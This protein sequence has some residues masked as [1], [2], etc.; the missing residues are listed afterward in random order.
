[1]TATVTVPI[2]VKEIEV[3]GEWKMQPWEVYP[4]R[5]NVV[6]NAG[7][8]ND[9]YHVSLTDFNVLKLLHKVEAICLESC[10]ETIDHVAICYLLDEECGEKDFIASDLIKDI[11]GEYIDEIAKVAFEEYRECWT[12]IN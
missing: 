7:V 8:C 11:V 1:M 9:I 5:S 3:L 4:G 6:F 12:K 10:A 2:E